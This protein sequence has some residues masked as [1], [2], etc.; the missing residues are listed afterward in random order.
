MGEHIRL[1][2]KSRMYW[3]YN[4]VWFFSC[5]TA[6]SVNE[7]S[8]NILY[9][10]HVE[11]KHHIVI[12]KTIGNSSKNNTIYYKL[13]FDRINNNNFLLTPKIIIFEIY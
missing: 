11:Q 7:N 2:T 10:S 6:F 12:F 9:N 8:L 3:F 4:N 13:D 1:W 5:T